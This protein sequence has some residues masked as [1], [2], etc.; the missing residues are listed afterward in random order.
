M[1]HTRASCAWLALLLALAA[2]AGCN[3]LVGPLQFDDHWLTRDLTLQDWRAWWQA[4]GHSIRPLLKVSY[5][6][7]HHAGLVIDDVPLAH[8]LFNVAV[9]LATIA[10]AYFLARRLGETAFD[11]VPSAGSPGTSAMAAG[12]LA[13]HPLATEAVT[14]VSGRSVSLAALFVLATLLLH[15]R[16][17][18]ETGSRRLS[19]TLFAG[20]S[21]ATAVLVREA[22]FVV[23]L[24]VLLWEWSRTD[25]P[26]VPWS[27]RRL[28]HAI[29]ASAP[30]AIV[31][32][33]TLAWLLTR[34]DYA[35]LVETSRV[36]S[37]GRVGEP[38]FLPAL[39][40]FGARLLLLAPLSID[41]DF[42]PHATGPALHWLLAVLLAAAAIGAWR[43]R[44]S[45]PNLLFGLVWIFVVLAP[46][47]LVP[48]RHDAIA[49]RHF[50]PALFGVGLMLGVELG[51]LVARGTRAAST[52]RACVGVL[53]CVF[54]VGTIS[55]NADYSTEVALWESTTE[56]SPTNPRAFHNLGIACM[57]EKDWQRAIDSFRRAVE[58]DPGY[59]QARD[60]LDRALLKQRTGDPNAEPEI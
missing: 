32:A 43:L 34:D 19:A 54:L 1:K 41:P 13:L 39:Q 57:K 17:A 29:R 31:S 9:H 48:L 44:A 40:Y 58:L 45:R 55:R 53:T 52:T 2:L 50:Y 5:V 14:Y 10:I 15:I 6:A 28:A 60:N 12:I 37:Q 35:G 7:S 11:R 59:R 56:A 49:E 16:G 27:G 18:T 23:P 24:L 46:M 26:D 51:R 30:L 42:R 3:G 21:L 20:I 36:L 25:L 47:Y 4:A 22:V 33:V 38:L 8:H